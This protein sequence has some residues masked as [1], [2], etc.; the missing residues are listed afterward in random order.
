MIDASVRFRSFAVLARIRLAVA[1]GLAASLAAGSALAD[2]P[3]KLLLLPFVYMQA[4]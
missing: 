1:T 2:P 3:P 4:Q